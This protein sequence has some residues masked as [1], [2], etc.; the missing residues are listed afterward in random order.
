MKSFKTHL[1]L[2]FPL[3]FIMFAFEFILVIN[4]TIRHYEELLNKDYNII[5]ASSSTLDEVNLKTRIPDLASIVSLDAKSM[6]QRLKNDVSAR[7]LSALEKSLP[8]FYS[9]KLSSLPSQKDL[10]QIKQKLTQIPS[11]LKVETFSKTYDKVYTLLVLVEFVLWLFSFIIIALSFTLFLKQMKIW[12][13]EHIQRVQILCLFG[14]PFWFRSFMLYKIVF[15]DC[16]VAFLLVLAFFTQ[17]YSLD[18]LMQSLEKVDIILPKINF[19]MHLGLI[20]AFV[21]CVSL[22]CVNSVMFKVK[23]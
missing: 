21:L 20:F 11:V 12:L 9:L 5:I 14:A 16:L 15:V 1:S 23:R 3:V 19:L 18:I 22:L 8:Q 13:F 7:N 17:V 10:E 6:I 4:A 2:I